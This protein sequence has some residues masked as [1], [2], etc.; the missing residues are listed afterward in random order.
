MFIY[1]KKRKETTYCSRGVKA[2]WRSYCHR[3]G[4][5]DELIVSNHLTRSHLQTATPSYK[6]WRLLDNWT[7]FSEGFCTKKA[8]HFL[9]K[10][11]NS[12]QTL[13]YSIIQDPRPWSNSQDLLPTDHV[14]GAI[15]MAVSNHVTC[16]HLQPATLSYK[17]W[18]LFD[19]FIA[20]WIARFLDSVAQEAGITETR[21]GETIDM[22]YEWRLQSSCTKRQLQS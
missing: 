14:C 3:N 2:S 11:P 20:F 17:M 6:M 16:S 22:L 7:Q 18:R 1:Q 10:Q 19:N 4:C 21:L 8:R 13:S 12:L 5:I 15:K 9:T